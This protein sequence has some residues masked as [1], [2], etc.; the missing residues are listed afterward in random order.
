MLSNS[1]LLCAVVVTLAMAAAVT[2]QAPGWVRQPDMLMARSDLRISYDDKYAYLAGG[3]NVS[4]PVAGTGCTSITSY[5]TRF[6]FAN[7]TF[8]VLPSL[9]VARYRYSS[10]LLNGLFYLIGGR[11][12]DDTFIAQVDGACEE[13]CWKIVVPLVVS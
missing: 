9:P 7:E 13:S 2:A 1:Q 3:C 8:E 12:L 4:Q 10:V 6:D 5:F 11:A